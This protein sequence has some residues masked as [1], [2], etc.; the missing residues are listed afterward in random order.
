MISLP[1]LSTPKYT[2]RLTTGKE[3]TYRPFLVKEEKTLLIAAQTG[4]IPTILNAVKDLVSATTGITDISTLSTIDLIWLIIKLRS[5]S[6][7]EVARFQIKCQN[8]ACKKNVECSYDLEEITMPD[9]SV[10]EKKIPLTNDIGVLMRLPTS[11]VLTYVVDPTLD[12]TDKLYQ[13]VADC[14][15]SIYTTTEVINTSEV[16]PA[17]VMRFVE[18]LSHGQ[19]EKLKEF[20]EKIP[21]IVKTLDVKCPHCGHENKMVLK[22]LFDFFV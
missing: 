6:V 15:E 11:K 12:N 14:I 3:I 5:K 16:S 2:T 17:E 13:I 22:G 10:L 20:Y 18:N 9:Y 4:E 19:F 8:D 7:G 21:M 1:T